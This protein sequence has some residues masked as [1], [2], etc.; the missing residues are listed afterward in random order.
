[1][2]LWI[3]KK[4]GYF[5]K[6][7]RIEKGLTQQEL[8]NQLNVTDKAI[9][10]W[11]TGRRLPDIS[12]MVDLSKK[13]DISI[14]DLLN[15]EELSSE[16]SQI[17]CEENIKDTIEIANKKIKKN[18]NRYCLI[19]LGVVLLFVFIFFITQSPKASSF[20]IIQN[21][22]QVNKVVTLKIKDEIDIGIFNKEIVLNTNLAIK[23]NELFVLEDDYNNS[24]K[25]SNIMT[26]ESSNLFSEL[27]QHLC[28]V[29]ILDD[30]QQIL[31]NATF[32]LDYFFLNKRDYFETTYTFEYK[33]V[34]EHK[35]KL[36]LID[37][38]EKINPQYPTYY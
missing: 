34:N 25:I 5:I 32:Q 20:E 8:A 24:N 35:L 27:T 19:L 22:N 12:L 10:N 15:G 38:K 26:I 21:S 4:I 37:E 16:Q 17:K 31:I 14:Q 9:S 13:L 7:K 23:D 3:K 1:M 29:S 11:E 2:N 33:I 6:T 18:K 28:I 30:K 36:K